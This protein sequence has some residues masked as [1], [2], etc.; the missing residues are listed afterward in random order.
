MQVPSPPTYDP[1]AAPPQAQV[2]HGSVPM[3]APAPQ[4][5]PNAQATGVPVT[6]TTAPPAVVMT[7][8]VHSN[9]GRPERNPVPLSVLVAT[10]LCFWPCCPCAMAW[11]VIDEIECAPGCFWLF[12][13][14]RF[15]FG[16]FSV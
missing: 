15:L 14:A 5:Y 2:M 1:K 7:H 9:A 10:V 3:Q 12:P 4:P 8:S 6:Q 13:S 16:C 11:V